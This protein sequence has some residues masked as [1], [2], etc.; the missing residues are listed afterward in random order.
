MCGFGRAR[1]RGDPH[2]DSAPTGWRSGGLVRS[3]PVD[4]GVDA[5]VMAGDDALRAGEWAAAEQCYRAVLESAEAGEALFGLG[6]ARWWSGDTDEALRCWERAYAVFRRQSDPG[7][8]VFSAVY[9]CL[10]FRMSLGNDAAARGWAA[11]AAELVEE[12]Q[13]T[14]MRGWVLLCRAY[15][16]NDEAHPHV[17]ER[18]AREAL[19]LA[20]AGGDADLRLCAMCELGAAL[21]EL[22]NLEDGAA[23]LDQAMAA[24]LA[25]E[26]GD[27]DTVVLISCRTITTCSRA[28]DIKRAV[29]WIRA[30]D[31]FNRR[32]G[33]TH[34]YTT[35]RTHYGS[36]LFAVGNW[37]QAE[38]ELRAAMKIGSGAEPVLHAEA[39]AKLAELRLAQGRLDDAEHLLSGLEDQ[40]VTT[41]ARGRLHLA[42]A[43]PKASIS[44]VRRRLRDLHEEYR[45]RACL[46][47]LLLEALVAKG[48]DGHLRDGLEKVAALPNAE[49]T[50]F[51]AYQRRALG[52][53]MAA[54]GER[55]AI[56]DLEAALSAFG[57]LDMPY[58]CGRTRL[59]LAQVLAE[60][61]RETAVADARAALMCFEQLGAAR[62]A[63]AAA[64]VLRSL[65]VRSPRTGPK[66]LGLLSKRELEILTLLGDG[67]ANRDIAERL[68]I[69]RKTV[70]HHV[71]SILSKLGLSGRAEATAYAVRH[72]EGSPASE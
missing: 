32:Y 30:A 67:L 13:L 40:P 38:E 19:E 69:S 20:R 6:I 31:D 10:A 70:E 22:G 3:R 18:W 42:R 44:L 39:A 12:F 71:A 48:D 55:S 29:Q 62:D 7:Q 27:L 68:Y 24:A 52:R 60:D 61:D 59:L 17:A 5:L 15:L 26:G 9:L 64:A 2:A 21:V 35:C 28:A 43:A 53:G 33:S 25:G 46:L 37:D 14:P 36:V 58:E 4:T 34:L 41:Y 47:D 51:A 11:R 49:A 1:S 57:L 66:G 23:L 50:L 16:A 54:L 65:G 8:A 63:D 72:L 45:E 56:E